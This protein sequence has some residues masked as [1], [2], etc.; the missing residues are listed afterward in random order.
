MT[1]HEPTAWTIGSD[2]SCSV[3]V[4]VPD[5]KPLH[6]EIRN[7][8]GVF[9]VLPRQGRIGVTGRQS[10]I[11]FIDQPRRILA[12]ERVY[13]T[14]SILLPWPSE[15]GAAAVLTVGRASDCDLTLD[16][17]EISGRHAILIVGRSGTHVLRDTQSR[18]GL[19]VDADF[20][21]RV[22]ACS[23]RP[24]Q[25][26]Y[27]GSRPIATDKFFQL[28]NS[29]SNDSSRPQNRLPSPLSA[30]PNRRRTWTESFAWL[31]LLLPVLLAIYLLSISFSG[32]ESVTIKPNADIQEPIDARVPDDSAKEAVDSTSQTVKA[33]PSESMTPAKVPVVQPVTPPLDVA[34]DASSAVDNCVYWV[35]ILNDET[36]TYFRL[37]TAIATDN[38]LLSTTG[39]IV[40]SISMMQQNGYSHPKVVHIGTMQEYAITASGVLAE[41]D[42]RVQT[43]D[44]LRQQYIQRSEAAKASSGAAN[45]DDPSLQ[46]AARL[47]NLAM[48]AAASADVGWLRI[49]K[50]V[51]HVSF[52]NERSVRPGLAVD[53]LNT[54]FDHEDPFFD[55]AEK[56]NL[57]WLALRV[58]G[59]DPEYDGVAG[60]L[61][62][63]ATAEQVQGLNLLGAPVVRDA[64][65]LGVV[66]FQA[67]PDEHTAVILEVV[68]AKTLAAAIPAANE[69][70][71]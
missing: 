17:P 12:S 8:N 21:R 24:N 33:P 27:L 1:R 34:R 31:P 71:P 64:A 30:D 57:D 55:S 6:C 68:T 39:S 61:R 63:K 50:A 53:L 15:Q 14:S 52:E 40:H 19:F 7:D 45:S 43:S 44:L 51:P 3:V 47:V 59:Q 23:L 58:L 22:D 46:Q 9:T 37:G 69:S 26:V 54:G 18:N 48:T 41:F 2:R 20:S 25:T 5:V 29:S 10:A 16:H 32:S 28:T 38:H 35:L 60:S 11:D 70:T 56:T 62:I 49:T 13:L 67:P 36:H 4:N 66:V 42:K 65:L